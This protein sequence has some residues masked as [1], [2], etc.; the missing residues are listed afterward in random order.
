MRQ[1]LVLF[2]VCVLSAFLLS[3][4]YGKTAPLI[5]ENAK[6]KIEASLKEV[7]PGEVEF[8]EIEPGKLWEVYRNGSLAGFVYIHGERGY[9]SV[10]RAMVG[11]DLD[12]KIVGMKV[13][14][15]GLSETPGLGM[16]VTEPWFSRQFIGKYAED[17]KLKKD[18]GDLDAITAATISSRACVNAVKNGYIELV[19]KRLPW[20]MKYI[21]EFAKEYG[22]EEVEPGKKWKVKDK[23]LLYL[24]EAEGFG[25][26]VQVLVLVDDK[27]KIEWIHIQRP[28]EGLPETEGYGT[29]VAT[30]EYEQRFIGKSA[31][32]PDVD[33]LTGASVTSR[34]VIEAVKEGYKG[35]E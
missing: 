34:A 30:Q 29:E 19:K 15:E 26:K 28:E 24:G 17:V 33:V 7:F 25:G 16:K 10:V 35:G 4:V 22:I 8:K 32:N 6:K 3:F 31:A 9:S 18:G 5:E 23:G 13:P 11:V 14:K 21:R 2:I 12:G 27:G 1:V 20:W